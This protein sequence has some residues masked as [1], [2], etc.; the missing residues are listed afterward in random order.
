MSDISIT[1]GNN[2]SNL[3]SGIGTPPFVSVDTENIYENNEM[4]TIDVITLNGRIRRTSCSENGFSD[5]YNL[6]KLLASRLQTSSRTLRVRETIDGVTSTIYTWDYAIP[7]SLTIEDNKWFDWIPYTVKFKCYKNGY[8]E[9]NG[10]IEPVREISAENNPDGTV[11]LTITCSCKGV[12]SSIAFEKAKLFVYNNSSVVQADLDS[13]CWT[14]DLL[15]TSTP[16]LISEVETFDRLN[17]NVSVVRTYVLQDPSLGFTRGVLRYTR[18]V[19]EGE[20]GEIT[21]SINGEH[22]GNFRDNTTSQAFLDDIKNHDWYKIALEAMLEYSNSAYSDPNIEIG[23]LIEGKEANRAT[24][25]LWSTHDESTETFIKNP[26]SWVSSLDMSGFIVACSETGYE[27]RKLGAL[28][29]PRHFLF[30][31]HFRAPIG[32][33]VYFLDKNGDLHTRTISN[34]LQT[35][36]VGVGI[37]N[38]DLPDTV[39]FYPILPR[40]YTRYIDLIGKH[41]IMKDQVAYSSFTGSIS[42]TTL[43]ASSVYQGSFIEP[44]Q[45][46]TGTGVS[47]GTT[48]V[49]QLTGSDGK[50]G[51]YVVSISQTVASTTI[52]GSGTSGVAIPKCTIRKIKAG[53]YD[54]TI[55]TSWSTDDNFTDFFEDTSNNDSGSSFFTILNGQ[56]VLLGHA[57]SMTS[58]LPFEDAGDGLSYH[59]RLDDINSLMSTLGGS[60][61]LT[62]IEP[63]IIYRSPTNFSFQRNFNKNSITFNI[64]FSNKINNEIYI[65]D[66]TTISL[67]NETSKN[68]ISTSLSI[69]SNY[70]A[71]LD[72]WN[73]VI[74]YYSTFNFQEYIQDKWTKYGNTT[75]LNFNT[76]QGQGYSENK[77]IGSIDISA[78]YCVDQG[79][80]CGCLQDLNYSYS[81]VPPLKEYKVSIPKEAQGCHYI[82]D[83]LVY[84]RASFSVKGNTRTSTCCTYGKTVLELK[85]RLNQI[86]NSMFFGEKKILDS[87]EISQDEN[88]NTISFQASWSAKKDPFIPDDLLE[89]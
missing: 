39:S 51:T 82:E 10:I 2:S 20:D 62:F 75:V 23:R 63:Q 30:A 16:Y 59:F 25:Y 49:S 4:Y 5:P 61:S 36:D 33:T 89:G 7:T 22:Q 35:N 21:V 44:G 57:Q 11:N 86:A 81:F 66:E 78:T 76:K 43:T 68:C 1:Y 8:F 37:L 9:T 85:N 56:I 26:N 83:M 15:K 45:V 41:L 73:A 65:I 88:G 77:Q 64:S 54:Y 55:G 46:L 70:K 48:I 52:T 6:L 32:T 3:F 50:D 34:H 58:V 28:I 53:T 29:S 84:K 74:N 71:E 24:K 42:G 40:D 60:Y 80:Y 13:L 19:V 12:G 69:R 17:S 14:S 18:E 27:A 87:V 72:R 47:V 79:Q 31:W 67:D 38:E